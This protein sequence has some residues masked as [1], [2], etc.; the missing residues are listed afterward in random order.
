MNSKNIA[1]TEEYQKRVEVLDYLFHDEFLEDICEHTF[2]DGRWRVVGKTYFDQLAPL[3]L[4]TKF[5][6]IYN[7][8]N[9]L[10]FE[11]KCYDDRRFPSYVLHANGMEYLFFSLDLYGYSILNLTTLK[12]YHYM[13]EE[14]LTGGETFIWTNVI[15]SG[16]DKIVAEGCYWACDHEFEIYDFN[17]P[18][19]LPYQL[20]IKH[21][22]LDPEYNHTLEPVGWTSPDEYAYDEHIRVDECA[23]EKVRKSVK[24]YSNLT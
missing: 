5:L 15:Y 7:H 4:R 9:K 10:I 21:E 17:V 12:V 23:Y 6:E 8:K 19:N 13:P 11:Q 2:A 18:E 16:I 22:D 3:A 14:V 20:L 1:Y 24:F